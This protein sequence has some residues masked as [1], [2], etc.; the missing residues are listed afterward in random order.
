MSAYLVFAREK[1]IDE[2]ELKLCW[3][4]IRATFDGH[5]VKVLVNYGVLRF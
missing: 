2:A 1:T 5:Q 4:K 3:D